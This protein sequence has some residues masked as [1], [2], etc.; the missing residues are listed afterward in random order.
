ML[1]SRSQNKNQCK[2]AVAESPARP[3]RNSDRIKIKFGSY[4]IDI[5]ENDINIRVS[6]LYSTRDGLR[7]NRTLAVV[8]YPDFIDAAFEKEHEAIVNG[9]SIG[10]VFEQNGW[11][12]DKQHQYLSEIQIPAE[13][14]G[15]DPLFGT[16]TNRPAIHIYSLL[17]SKNTYRF[18][19]ALIAEI[20]HPEFLQLED[21]EAIYGHGADPHAEDTW[22]VQDFLQIVKTKIQGL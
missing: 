1:V 14:A 7:T 11:T 4:D 19:Y 16:A 10:V 21:L 13:Y 22:R 8:S 17:V 5:I 18:N 9:Q 12:I 2:S 3:L 20:H 15:K 6:K